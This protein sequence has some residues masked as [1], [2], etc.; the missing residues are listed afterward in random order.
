MTTQ[1]AFYKWLCDHCAQLCDTEP[2][3]IVHER[4]MHKTST[5]NENLE[6]LEVKV[7]NR[8]DRRISP[9]KTHCYVMISLHKHRLPITLLSIH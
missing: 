1:C 7:C 5:A 2:N 6:D 3:A 9:I 4:E 8:I